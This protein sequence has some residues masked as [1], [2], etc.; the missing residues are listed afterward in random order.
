MGYEVDGQT[1]EANASG[2]LVDL[3]DWNEKVAVA[4]A[5]ADGIEMTQKHWDLVNYLRDEYV[6]NASNQPNTR[7][8]VKAMQ[9]AWNDNK[10]DTKVLFELF[11]KGPDKQAS[12]VAGLPES[13]RKGGY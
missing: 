1:V 4:I 5:A 3:N 10:L 11:P 9:K 7:T 6:N 8:I 2:Y 13:K 12:K